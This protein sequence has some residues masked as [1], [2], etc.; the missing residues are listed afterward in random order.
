[1]PRA[2]RLP[3]R[4]TCALFG[5]LAC[6]AQASTPSPAPDSLQPLLVTMNERL[7]IADLVA[8]TKWD[9]GKPI[10][11][12]TREAL[13]IANA[14]RWLLTGNWTRMRWPN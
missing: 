1:M 10:Q 12:S 5:L 13:V 8:L 2:P 6:V 3:L 11:D 9:S 14:R 4:L 7:I